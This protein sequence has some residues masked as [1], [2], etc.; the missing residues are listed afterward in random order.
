MMPPTE[1][2]EPLLSVSLVPLAPS[3][4]KLLSA[5][6]RLHLKRLSK[7]TGTEVDAVPSASV[8]RI[9]ARGQDAAAAVAGA[10]R[11]LLRFV[12]SQ[13]VEVFVDLATV[14][15]SDLSSSSSPASDHPSSSS[16]SDG[17]NDGSRGGAKRAAAAKGVMA[18]VMGSEDSDDGGGGGGDGDGGD[19]GVLPSTRKAS[20]VVHSRS[21]SN[22]TIRRSVALHGCEAEF[23]SVSSLPAPADGRT[24]G[25]VEG[26][27]SGHRNRNNGRNDGAAAAAG[28]ENKQRHAAQSNKPKRR[29]SGRGGGGGASANVTTTGGPGVGA[30]AI[31]AS[32]VAPRNVQSRGVCIRGP[33]G[34]VENARNA[35]VAL[36]LGRQESEIALGVGAAAALGADNWVR[37][38]V[39]VRSSAEGGGGG[40]QFRGH[41]GR[42]TRDE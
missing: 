13:Q 18:A 27:A 32:T 1:K 39:W 11:S 30:G 33:P 7:E 2:Q 23:V 17:R 31:P 29:D 19:G 9:R 26:G 16:S 20:A 42:D 38:Q 36:V 5:R 12:G 8:V 41:D 24:D 10:R 34:L 15:S 3:G 21:V 14:S 4:M 35:L 25:G 40:G 22:D 37:I 28:G 6:G